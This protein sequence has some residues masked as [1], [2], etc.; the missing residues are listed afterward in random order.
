MFTSYAAQGY[1]HLSEMDPSD[2]FSLYDS[3][4]GNKIQYQ[5]MLVKGFDQ[6]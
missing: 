2:F 1:L 6:S 4:V 3:Y 5:V